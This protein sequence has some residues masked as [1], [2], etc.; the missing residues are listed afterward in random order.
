MNLLYI[1]TLFG[2]ISVSG[3][4]KALNHKLD[5]LG[6][7]S[8]ITATGGDVLCDVLTGETPFILKKVRYTGHCGSNTLLY[9]ARYCATRIHTRL[10]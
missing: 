2:V 5:I 6:V 1:L 7:I 9:V 4:L 3:A 8:L 10:L